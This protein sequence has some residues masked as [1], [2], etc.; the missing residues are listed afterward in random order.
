MKQHGDTDPA[1][2]GN[3]RNEIIF[4]LNMIHVHHNRDQSGNRGHGHK[5]Q[6]CLDTERHQMELMITAIWTY[7][8]TLYWQ[9]DLV[10]YHIAVHMPAQY[11]V[12]S[13]VSIHA[14]LNLYL[15]A[16]F[17]YLFL[18]GGNLVMPIN[19]FFLLAW[20]GRNNFCVKEE[21]LKNGCRTETTTFCWK[22]NQHN[23]FSV[24]K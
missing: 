24:A 5:L 13:N 10:S 18:F 17:L 6:Y 16:T 7:H 2:G 21:K 20:K 9:R 3:Y 23:T 14:Q 22:A 12:I 8:S 11:D 4:Q 19:Y 1:W 15:Q